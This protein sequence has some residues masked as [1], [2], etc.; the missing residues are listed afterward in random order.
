MSL[1]PER[2][3]TK[4]AGPLQRVSQLQQQIAGLHPFLETLFPIEPA[5]DGTFFIFE[6]NAAA[7]AYTPTATAPMPMPVPLGVRATF[8]LEALDNRPACVI[9]AEVFD[10]LA[11]YVTVFHEFIHCQQWEWG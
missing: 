5:E 3:A 7:H 11:A 2:I 1:T 10:T 8:P 9:T 6:L 4:F